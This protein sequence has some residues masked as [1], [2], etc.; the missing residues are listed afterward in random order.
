MAAI[1]EEKRDN[2]KAL[3][4]QGLSVHK[5]AE[6]LSVSWSVVSKYQ[7]LI[8]GRPDKNRGGR[9]AA[10][11]EVDCRLIAHRIANSEYCNA[12]NAADHLAHEGKHVNPQTVRNILKK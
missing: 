11:S 3:T 4:L 2:I 8:K 1:S 6:R 10:M 12:V 5:I 7:Q 9:P